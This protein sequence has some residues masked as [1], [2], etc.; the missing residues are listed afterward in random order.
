MRGKKTVARV[1][2]GKRHPTL[3]NLRPSFPSNLDLLLLIGSLSL[4][5]SLLRFSSELTLILLAPSS[6]NHTLRVGK[7]RSSVSSRSLSLAFSSRCFGRDSCMGSD[8]KVF[9]LAEVSE[10]GSPEDCWLVIEGKVWFVR[11]RVSK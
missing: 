7:A 8:I 4:S 5:L 2:E 1:V 10:H 3:S 9:T 6:R 11:S